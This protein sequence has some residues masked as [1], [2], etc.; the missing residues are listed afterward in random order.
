MARAAEAAEIRRRLPILY[1]PILAE[2]LSY[3]SDIQWEA[4]YTAR[5]IATTEELVALYRQLGDNAGSDLRFT[6]ALAQAL[7]ALGERQS[8]IGDMELA[9]KNTKEAAAIVRKL[10]E[11]NEQNDAIAFASAASAFAKIRATARIELT[12]SDRIPAR[13]LLNLVF[14]RR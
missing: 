4:G 10:A 6:P 3:L 9:L 8:E 1:E 11:S 14:L 13:G 5:A 2:T 7:V 12:G